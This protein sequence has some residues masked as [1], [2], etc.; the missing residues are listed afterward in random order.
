M[1]KCPICN[2]NLVPVKHDKGVFTHEYQ[3]ACAF[4]WNDL[5]APQIKV[6]RDAA[7]GEAGI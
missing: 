2:D 3:T 5:T 7:I 4:V 6:L 1:M